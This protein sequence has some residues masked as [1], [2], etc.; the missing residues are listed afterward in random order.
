MALGREHPLAKREAD[1]REIYRRLQNDPRRPLRR[2]GTGHVRLRAP[3][4]SLAAELH[5]E[6]GSSL[7]IT[8]GHKPFPPERIRDRH[9]VPL[10]TPTV[11]VPGLEL[12]ITVDA[13]R[14]A[15][16]ETSEAGWSSPTEDRNG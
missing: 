4:A 10:P 3:F 6:Y 16:G 11:A 2:G 13:P 9:V 14:L 8:V 5:R 12:T 1:I 7:E 15:Q